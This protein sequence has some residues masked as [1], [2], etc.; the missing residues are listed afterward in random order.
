MP[1]VSVERVQLASPDE[2]SDR[3]L[4]LLLAGLFFV[5]GACGLV[6]QQLWLRELTLVFGVTVHAVST[7]LA[8][9]FSGLA[10]GSVVAGRLAHRTARP[11]HWYGVA[12]IAIGVLAVLSPLTFDVVEGVYVAIAD[13]VPDS[14]VLLTGVRFVLAFAALIVPA[15]LMGASLPL[16]MKSS[17]TRS[18]RLGER[19]SVLYGANTTGAIFGTVVAG[20]VL[21]GRYGII[22]SFRLA[23][24]ANVVVGVVAIV[25]S[26][27]AV[28]SPEPE[29][30]LVKFRRPQGAETS[31]DRVQRTVLAVFIVSGFVAIALEVVWFRVLVLYLESNTYAFTIMLAT[32]LGGI[33]LG[34]FLAAP[35]LAR[36]ISHLRVLVVVECGVAIAAASS[37]Q[38]LSE[39]Y[40]VRNRLSD[41]VPLIDGDLEFVLIASALAILPT[42]VLMGVAFPIG[43]RLYVGDDPDSGRRIGVFYGLNVAAG[44]AGSLAAGFVLVPLIGTRRSLIVLV[45]V[46]AAAAVAIAITAWEA[47][48]DRSII[49]VV[50][51]VLGALVLGPAV[52]NPYSAA[53]RYRYPDERLLWIE[54]GAQTTVSIQEQSDGT[55][56]MYLDGLHQAN[57]TAFMVGYH[58]L[59]GTLAVALHHD[60]REALV[61]GLGGGVTAHG[62]SSIPTVHVE[63][64]ELSGEV[65]RG[66]EYLDRANEG[67]VD[68]PNVDIKV[69]DGRNHLLV[70]EKRYDVITA[71]VIQPVHAGAGKVWSIEYWELAREA[72]AD[73]GL[74]LQWVPDE[75]DV[76]YEM[77]VRSFLEVFPEATAWANGSMLVGTREPLRIDAGAFDERLTDP[78]TRVAMES[79]GIVDSTSLAGLYT[80]GPDELRAFVGAGPVLDDDHP[81]VEYFR[82]LGTGTPQRPDLTRLDGDPTDVFDASD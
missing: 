34:S 40:R 6:Y 12:E 58:R 31:R 15:T 23:A 82:T 7:V 25:A 24:L 80:A 63:V 42:T 55:R 11:L 74:M 51:V 39:A 44:I 32:V 3:R 5:S 30:D 35:L 33:A 47:R 36:R 17:L 8:A 10:L 27:R 66:A 57:D 72:L 9:F 76:H 26:R 54:E 46:S 48:R 29:P 41:L 79:V 21:I 14:R 18:A 78:L 20:F 45:L 52:P 68:R 81:R 38:F 62:V 49:A 69:D 71:D 43:V 65:V 64:V 75:R 28:N 13:V 16:V 37:L 67:V 19:V 73:G 53:L 77:I 22:S 1:A 61:V 2:T 56:V 50:A 59:I 4:L 60:P 70:T